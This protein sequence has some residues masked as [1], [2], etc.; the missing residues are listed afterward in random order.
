MISLGEGLGT[1][2]ALFSPRSSLRVSVSLIPRCLEPSAH[3]IRLEVWGHPTIPPQ[4]PP[5][6]HCVQ[7]LQTAPPEGAGV[8]P[9]RPICRGSTSS[10][11]RTPTAASWEGT[12]LGPLSVH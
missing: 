8:C 10:V 12:S 4:A 6:H 5:R 7:I 3:Y 9:L 11:V 2:W 1:S